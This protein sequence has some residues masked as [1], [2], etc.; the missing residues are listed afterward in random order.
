MLICLGLS[1]FPAASLA[2]LLFLNML[3]WVETCNRECDFLN[4]P[5]QWY[6]QT[7]FGPKLCLFMWT[8]M[9]DAPDNLII[10]RLK[11]GCYFM[12]KNVCLL[13][14]T[15]LNFCKKFPV[16]VTWNT[17]VIK[18]FIKVYC[19]GKVELHFEVSW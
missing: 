8:C 4:L 15:R 12:K 16:L 5:A 18:L 2:Q 11:R 1:H 19:S 14:P 3:L 17:E 7:H 6:F 13:P 10:N 9:A